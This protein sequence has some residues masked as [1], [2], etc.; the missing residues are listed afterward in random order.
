MINNRH[1]FLAAV[2]LLSIGSCSQLVESDYPNEKSLDGEKMIVEATFGD[3]AETR[4]SFQGTDY[5]VIYWTPGDEINLFY[6]SMTKSR[7]TSTMT[8]ASASASFEGSLSAATGSSEQGVTTQTFWGVYPYDEDNDCDGEGVTLKIKG[9]Q[10]SSPNSFGK[11][12]NPSVANSPGLSLSFYNVGGWF[13][14]SVTESGITSVT[15]SGNAGEDI[16]GKVRV[17]M[18]SSGK[19]V[20]EVVEGEG[21]KTITVTPEEGDAFLPNTEYCFTVIP[22]TLEGGF[23]FTMY[24]GNQVAVRNSSKRLSFERSYFTRR[25]GLDNGLTWQ[26]LDADTEF[27][28]DAYI[29]YVANHE[30]WFLGGNQY[31]NDT[32]FTGATGTRFEMKFQIPSYTSMSE[33]NLASQSEFI[34]TRNRII[35]RTETSDDQIDTD[36]ASNPIDGTSVIVLS[37]SC[38]GS[39]VTAAVNGN[40]KTV[41]LAL[42]SF[43]LGYLFSGYFHDYDEGSCTAYYAGVPDGAKLYYVKIWNG[44]ELVYFGHAARANCPCSSNIEYCWYEELSQT[45]TFAREL[46]MPSNAEP[47][48]GNTSNATVRQPFGG[49]VDVAVPVTGITLNKTAIAF[50]AV[51]ETDQLIATVTPSDATISTVTWSSSAKTVATVRS[52]GTVTAVGDGSATIIATANDGSGVTAECKV[53]VGNIVFADENVKSIC[54]ANWDTNGDG[55]LSYVEAAAVNSIG[56][57]FRSNMDIT[58]FDE[59]QYFT[60]LTLIADYAFSGCSNLTSIIIP[61]GA[62]YIAIGNYAFSSCSS[63]TNIFI[64][65]H[66]TSI[67][68]YAFSDCSNLVSITLADDVQVIWPYAFNNCLALSEISTSDSS[69]LKYLKESIFNNCPSLKRLTLPSTVTDIYYSDNYKFSGAFYGSSLEVLEIY[70]NLLKYASVH[71]AANTYSY[72]GSV[73]RLSFCFWSN[74]YWNSLNTI[75]KVVVKKTEG[76]TDYNNLN[77]AFKDFSSLETVSLPDNVTVTGIGYSA[78]SGCSSLLAF[79]IPVSVTSIADNAFYGCSG[80]TSINIPEGVTSI[81]RN[82]FYGC[83]SLT[84]ITCLPTVCPTGGS[85]MFSGSDCPIYVPSESVDAYKTAQNW[86]SYASR[87]QAIQ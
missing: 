45:Y 33:V 66:V 54:V 62:H 19:P 11:G 78:F 68:E 44:D 28:E 63:L 46:S 69:R 82:A 71:N 20:S 47:G 42:S 40:E 7:F 8:E 67:G 43:D 17:T 21:L 51:G 27:N 41:S 34:V 26:V 36:L 73:L 57:V 49:G 59:F 37:A 50:D 83:G 64:P 23:T 61:A 13:V 56:T 9:A 84:A 74:N 75:K 60:G 30:M 16:A 70:D 86:S 6:G 76:L 77:S 29:T 24:K 58:S 52:D 39:Q 32:Y 18:D 31:V 10:T 22:Q 48:Y 87:I 72:S 38:N 25:T 3:S 12:M 4:T 15:F 1:A 85:N 81:G 2:L 65:D 80:L 14:F 53:T 79:N 5:K 55:E 35:Y